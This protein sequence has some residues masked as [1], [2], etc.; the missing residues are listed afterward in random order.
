MF[1]ECDAMI[2]DEHYPN[3]VE[4]LQFGNVGYFS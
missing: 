1:I 2:A 3:M 4:I